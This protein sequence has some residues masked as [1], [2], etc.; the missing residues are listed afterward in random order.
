MTNNFNDFIKSYIEDNPDCNIRVYDSS[1]DSSSHNTI[2]QSVSTIFDK[3]NFWKSL[4]LKLLPEDRIVSVN[5]I[6]LI[7]TSDHWSNR[8]NVHCASKSLEFYTVPRLN[9]LNDNENDSVNISM[10]LGAK[11]YELRNS[12]KND[13]VVTSIDGFY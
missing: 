13:L 9:M 4:Q 1:N 7:G 11:V 12:L 5:G 8:R 6:R 2:A 3:I 10:V